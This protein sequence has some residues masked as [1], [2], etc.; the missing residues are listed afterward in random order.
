MTEATT[1][2]SHDPRA[3]AVAR[4]VAD[5]VHPDTVILFGSRARG[6]FAPDSDIDLLIITGPGPLSKNDYSRASAAAFRKADEVYD[7]LINV[8]LVRLNRGEFDEGRRARNHVAGQAVRDGFHPN[9]EKVVYDNPDPSNWPDIQ[10]RII[11]AR[12]ELGVLIILVE[13]NAA[14]EAVGFHAQQALENALKGWISAL[15]ADY[16]S[17]HDL[18]ELADIVR[19]HPAETA[20]PA[21]ER[22]SWLTAYAVRYRYAGARDVL[23]D[24]AGLLSSVTETVEAIIDRIGILTGTEGL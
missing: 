9:G 14:Q 21:G 13:G 7:S 5:E 4:A 19:R 17:T 12:R 15:D 16:R 8:D 20:T 2:L 22:L 18:A 6:D 11:N 3:C 23:R 24:Q 10:Q 1:G